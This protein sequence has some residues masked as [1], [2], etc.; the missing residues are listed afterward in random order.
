M[1]TEFLP[2]QIA[3]KTLA[4]I[5]FGGL[6]QGALASA[7]TETLAAAS[8]FIIGRSF[9]A[10]KLRGFSVFGSEPV[11][12]ASWFYSLERAAKDDGA[13]LTLLLRLAPVLP[14]PFDS[15]WYLLGALDVG[16]GDFAAAHFVGCLKT[17]FLDAS[18]GMLLL[19]SVGNDGSAVQSQAQQIVLVESIAF[20]VVAILV[21][22][23]A[24]R[25]ISELLG[26]EDA[27][28]ATKAESKDVAMLVC[29][30][31][32][33][34]EDLSA[35]KVTGSTDF[36]LVQMTRTIQNVPS[37]GDYYDMG[38][39]VMP[40]THRY[41]KVNFAVR[42]SDKQEVVVKVRF[43]PSCFRSRQ[44]EKKWRQNTEFL[45]NLPQNLGV[46]KI[47]EVMED[48]TAFYI[49][50]E[51]VPASVVDTCEQTR[52]AAPTECMQEKKSYLQLAAAGCLHLLAGP[53]NHNTALGVTCWVTQHLAAI[54]LIAAALDRLTAKLP[55][56]I[57]QDVTE[58]QQERIWA[59]AAYGFAGQP[60]PSV[61]QMISIC[62]DDRGSK[63]RA[64]PRKHSGSLGLVTLPERLCT[65]SVHC[66]CCHEQ[67]QEGCI[68][69]V[70]P[71]GHAFCEDCIVKWSMSGHAMSAT[72]PLCRASFAK[73]ERKVKC[74]PV[75]GLDLFETLEQMRKIPVTTTREIMRQLLESLVFLHSHGAVHKDLKLE[76]VM[77]DAGGEGKPSKS[78][79]PS[80]A[81]KVIDFD[82]LESWCPSNASAK[83]VVGTDQYISQEAYAGK[84]SPLSDIFA[85]GVILY[86]LLTGKFPFHDDMFDDEAGEN[87]VGSP[88]MAQIRRR[89]KVAK[90][91]FSKEVFQENSEAGDLVMRMLA[92]QENQRPTASAAL[93]HPWFQDSRAAPQLPPYI[94]ELVDDGIVV[95]EAWK[96]DGE[97]RRGF[98]MAGAGFEI[99]LDD[100]EAELSQDQYEKV[101]DNFKL[102]D[103][104]KTGRLNPQQVGI[105][106]R[107]FGQNP[108]DEELAEMLRPVPQVGLDVDGF[109]RFFK[110]NYRTPTTEDT[111][112]KAFQ[113]FDLEDTGIMSREKFKEML[114]SL[115][116]PMQ[117][118]EVDAILREAEVDDK[119]LFDYKSLAKRLCEGPKRI[120]DMP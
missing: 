102:L 51:K 31:V 15:Y 103:Q 77:L 13:R 78:S 99:K 93:E 75:G 90:V 52:L 11:G 19:T 53:A 113:V 28:D 45:L 3:L 6:V 9:L 24:T 71:C 22:T 37:F 29:S 67:F 25:L 111:L 36:H 7:A 119:G 82:T 43:K 108:T 74:A 110:G 66:W 95:G 20:A 84:Y 107:A 14:L 34:N 91:D 92:Y 42:K 81:V 83:D 69:A 27:A 2:I 63:A 68:V 5:I 17:A 118:H 104:S 12:K 30:P 57:V 21:S 18:F 115:G 40:S 94:Q 85:C 8:N 73:H 86:R 114:T 64:T 87:W 98:A 89:L 58:G 49:V 1:L 100:P 35:T 117:E 105:L 26:L 38:K 70:L 62:R 120:P 33:S 54:F 48:P 109:I 4:P 16:L 61:L 39:E 23:V 41:M 88:K 97:T 116:D 79:L 56:S 47:Y 72:C 10:D 80:Q 76:N 60:E 96:I 46:A 50:M 32:Q 65:S 106:F 44:D 112:L 55:P 59:R 101:V